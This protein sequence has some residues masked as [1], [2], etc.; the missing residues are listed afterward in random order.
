MYAYILTNSCFTCLSMVL[1]IFR[2]PKLDQCCTPT[3]Q[4]CRLLCAKIV[5]NKVF[6]G[7]ILLLIAASSLTLCFEDVYLHE[8]PHLQAI[9]GYLN[10][11][12]AILFVTEMTLKLMAFGVKTYFTVFWSVL[13]F[14]I[15][16]VS[17]YVV[18][19][20]YVYFASVT[21]N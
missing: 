17:V 14:A 15:V 16:C 21:S 5:T 8:K 18:I 7:F 1:N 20:S 6:E 3:W 2:N 11:V 4:N 10:I 19:Y 13:D 9:L 12:F